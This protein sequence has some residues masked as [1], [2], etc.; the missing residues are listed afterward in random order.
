MNTFGC[1]LLFLAGILG[2]AALLRR[3]LNRVRHRD[4]PRLPGAPPS[5]ME[6]VTTAQLA[7]HRWRKPLP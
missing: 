4:T 1:S 2:Y 7:E 6:Y 5:A 3:A